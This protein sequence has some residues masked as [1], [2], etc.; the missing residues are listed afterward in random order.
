MIL[1]ALYD[2]HDPV[3]SSGIVTWSHLYSF[4]LHFPL[5]PVFRLLKG[6][7]AGVYGVPPRKAEQEEAAD[8]HVNTRGLAL[9][10][11]PMRAC[12]LSLLVS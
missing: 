7:E 9:G 6:V 2:T 12:I 8:T 10:P 4:L 1:V 3:S 11:F 5:L